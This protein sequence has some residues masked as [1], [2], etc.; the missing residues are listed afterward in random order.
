M[1]IVAAP[2]SGAEWA[3]MLAVAL[4]V[5]LAWLLGTF[6]SALL[7]A[8]AH[9]RDILQEGSGNPGASNVARVLGWRAGA[10][11]LLL[12][13]AKARWPRAAGC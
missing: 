3:H 8:R 5:P 10:I 2:G 4:V 12:D 9:G 13:F 6:P 7:V 11:V 1:L